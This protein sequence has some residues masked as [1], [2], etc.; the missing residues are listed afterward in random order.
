MTIMFHV[1]VKLR[2]IAACCW[3]DSKVGQIAL[4]K[5]EGATP[6]SGFHIAA[7]LVGM[8][9]LCFLSATQENS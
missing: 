5:Y 4:T 8:N 2:Y 1:F 9:F 6:V 7:E 3:M